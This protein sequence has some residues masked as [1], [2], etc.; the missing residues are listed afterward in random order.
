MHKGTGL[1][2]ADAATDA[3]VAQGGGQRHVTTGKR[4]AQAEDVR[5]H[6]GVF[7]GKH[8][9]SAA[10]ASGDLIENQQYIK[11]IA[12]GAQLY[13]VPGGVKAHTARTLNHRLYNHRGNLLVVFAQQLGHGCQFLLRAVFSKATCRCGD[14]VLARQHIAEQVVHARI[15]VAHRHGSE[16]VTMITIAQ[17]HQFLLGRFAHGIPVL[18]GHFQCNFYGD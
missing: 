13:Q 6:C 3:R 7:Q 10:E 16:G 9:A 1:A 5:F 11:G 2:L 4:L 15:R 17:C 12:Q 14:K 8:L 18:D